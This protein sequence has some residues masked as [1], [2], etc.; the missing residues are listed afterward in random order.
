[1]LTFIAKD[2]NGTEYTIL[3]VQRSD[4]T[5]TAEHPG[6]V[7]RDGLASLRTQDGRSVIRV[8]R[9]EYEIIDGTRRTRV[10]S[11]DPNEP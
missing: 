2:S 4:G 10:W 6:A 9:G 3:I 7:S 1:M 11:D 5:E 8:A